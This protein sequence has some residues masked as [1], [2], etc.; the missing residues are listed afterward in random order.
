MAT[1]NPEERNMILI[2]G[3]TFFASS[4]AGIFVTVFLFINSDLKTTLFYCIVMNLSFLF[5]YMLSGWVMK[6]IP[7]GTLL[8]LSL[9]T[10]T[11][12]FF[13]L[14]ILKE[15]A[16]QFLIPLAVLDGFGGGLY[17]AGFNLNQYVFSSSES[18][19]QY[20]GWAGAVLNVFRA[21]GP[22]LGGAIVALTGNQMLFGVKAGYSVLFLIVGLI[23]LAVLTF[24]EKL[25]EHEMVSFS[26][27]HIIDHKRSK[28]WLNI[29][30]Q[31]IA[32]GL[33]DVLYSTMLGVL[34]F[35]IVKKEFYL[36]TV[37]TLGF[38]ASI[39]G[40]ILA[41]RVLQ[42]YK[43]GFW[44]GALGQAAGMLLFALNQNFL[45]I[46]FYILSSITAPFL[47][48]WMNTVYF[49][50]MDKDSRHFSEKY[51]LIAES[52][53]SLMSARILSY[54]FLF[55]IIGY[56]DQI[57]LAKQSLFILPIFPLIIGL[58]L[59]YYDKATNRITEELEPVKDFV[60]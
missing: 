41:I 10:A 19:V 37:Q 22:I 29:L 53:F 9:G 48:T 20:F 1:L 4:L 33:Y 59:S 42:K 58:L 6:K 23:L 44:V 38:T 36:G 32:F 26:L 15:K 56:G 52:T 57:Q 17:W 7:S 11:I 40:S 55:I 13:L 34:M 27:Q 30:G 28:S 2:Q 45:G 50:A 14:F 39:I 51:H 3:L 47:N 43:Q 35:L 31:Q 25:P 60:S 49:K 54:I 46:I 24:I 12:Y 8:K 18:R 16:I 21:I 5:F